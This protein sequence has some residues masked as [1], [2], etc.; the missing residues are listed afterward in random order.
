M[1]YK[2][3]LL[4]LLIPHLIQGQILD[5]R[6]QGIDAEIDSLMRTYKTPGIAIQIIENQEV[7][8]SQGFGYRNYTEKLPVTEH[9]LFPIGSV[10]KPLTASLMGV[11]QGKGKV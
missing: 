3:L 7:L 11:Y 4:S 10:T 8:F 5:P 2:L 1:K 6:L 9:T